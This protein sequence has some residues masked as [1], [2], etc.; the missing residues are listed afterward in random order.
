MPFSIFLPL[1]LF[2]MIAGVVSY[3]VTKRQKK[4]WLVLSLFGVLVALGTLGVI[5]LAVN[6]M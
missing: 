3:F 2:L 4:I 1:G 6:S 5:T